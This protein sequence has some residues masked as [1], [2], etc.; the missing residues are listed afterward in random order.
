MHGNSGDTEKREI[1]TRR[2]TVFS[3]AFTLLIGG[4]G[5]RL[6]QLQIHQ[7]EKFLALA[8]ENQFNRRVLTPLRGEIVDRFGVSLASNRQNFRLLLAPRSTPDVEV[9]L[10]KIAE[11]I[12]LSPQR[13]ERIM[14][15]IRR[16]GGVNPVQVADNL[17]WDEFSKLSYETP[18]LPG[19]RPDVGETRNYPLGSATAFVIGYVGAVT[20]RDLS[21]EQNADDRKLLRQP[22]FKV[23]RDGLERTYEK[24]LRGN[25]GEMQVQVNAHGRVLKEYKDN[26]VPAQQGQTLALTIDAELQQ[27]TME[28]LKG[29][30]ASAVVIDIETGD[31]LVLA[32]TPA[33]D[34][35]LFNTGIPTK[36]WKDLNASPYK[37]LLNKPLGGIYPPGST[38]KMVSAIAA[39]R[40]GISANHSVYCRGKIYYGKRYFHC[41]KRGGHGRMTMKDSLKHSC[42]VFYYD[43]A[44][45]LDIDLLADT[46][47]QL[48]LGQA[49]N[50]GVPG[51]RK[52]IVPSRAW[53]KAHYA[54][55]PANQI[56]FPGETLSVVIGQGAVTSTPLQLA[57]M[58]AR[59]ASGRKVLPRMVRMVGD[60]I[61]PPGDFSKINIPQEYFDTARAGMDAVSNEV[62]GTAYRSRLDNPDW[63]LAGKTGTSQIY[64][65]TKEE[66]ARGLTK[67]EDLP[68][69][70]RDHALFVCFAP[71]DSPRYACSVV[72]EHGIGGSRAAAPRARDIMRAVLQKDPGRLKPVG[73]QSLI[74]TSLTGD[75]VL[76]PNFREMG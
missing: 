51:E 54:N 48:G 35:N 5:A 61:T 34:P 64:R 44:Q 53:K 46:A 24:E 59:I 27:K 66:R 42:D 38:F 41:W 45:K 3:G 56:W 70:R 12:D 74:T 4:I 39:Q 2:A 6:Y 52:G 9:A 31:I 16:T 40:A 49:Y 29:E 20:D 73:P 76:P 8:K 67:P 25:S 10:E 30:S 28:V 14:R 13:C 33:F 21:S 43:I 50:L 19:A 72:V 57:V 18:S 58:A 26:A 47:E 37:P 69:E 22:G 65:I 11:H 7:H 36:L 15:E 1:F 55:S 23:G 62:G 63:R 17:S 75:A 60:R 68:W 71:F 32:S